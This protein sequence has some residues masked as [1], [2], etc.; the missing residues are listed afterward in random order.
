[1]INMFLKMLGEQKG[2][3]KMKNKMPIDWDDIIH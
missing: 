1:M 3:L 2:G